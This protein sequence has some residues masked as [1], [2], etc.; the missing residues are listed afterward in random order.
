MHQEHVA[1]VNWFRNKWFFRICGSD[2]AIYLILNSSMDSRL[3]VI[4]KSDEIRLS[5]II[6][7][8]NLDLKFNIQDSTIELKIADP[9]LFNKIE[10]YTEKCLS[11]A[12]NIRNA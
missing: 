11:E 10:K 6:Y 1:L 5:H 12:K 7:Y 2:D 8:V 9:E 3:Y 4:F